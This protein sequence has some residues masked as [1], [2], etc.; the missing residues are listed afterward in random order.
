[1]YLYNI[2]VN[3]DRDVEKEWLLWMQE[4][5]IPEIL[6]TGLFKENKIFRLLHEPHNDG[7]TY[8]LQFFTTSLKNLDKYLNEHAPSLAEKLNDRYKNK[9]VAFQTV[10]E[11]IE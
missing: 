1:M 6:N 5:H 10:M 8:S 3:I 7:S 2:T 11:F 9:H 4:V